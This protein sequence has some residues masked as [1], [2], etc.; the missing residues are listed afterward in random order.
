MAETVAIVGAGLMGRVLALTLLNRGFRVTLF[1]RDE[2]AAL[3]SC[4]YTGAGMLAPVSEMETASPAIAALGI[5]ALPLWE[6]L[7]TELPEPVFFQRAGTLLVAHIPEQAE[8]ARLM[9]LLGKKRSLLS[10]WMND[11]LCHIS[12]DSL[13]GATQDAFSIVALHGERLRQLES[14][15]GER[16]QEGFL[17]TDEGQ[18]D[19]RQLLTAT[20]HALEKQNIQ[21]ISG[22]TVSS[23]QLHAVDGRFFDRVV[24]CRGLGAKPDITQLRGVRGEL[25]RV[26]AP[27][28]RITRPIRLMHPRYPLYIAPREANDFVI[29]ATSLETEN[30]KPM[31]LQSALELLS[32]ACSIHP[33][34]L[35]ASILE[36][37]VN[38]RPTLSSHLPCI[39]VSSGLL[40][41]N[42]LYRHGFLMAPKLAALIADWLDT[43]KPEAP[44]E[45]LFE[46]M[47]EECPLYAHFN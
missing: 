33:G 18:I 32:A 11:D 17:I 39:Q 42:G 45:H 47:T 7:I 16:F 44:Y 41:V 8:L 15:L 4:A 36:M 23:I 20:K 10:G 12:S 31:T 14:E 22:Y 28:V 13:S 35:E 37:G 30:Q 34:F 40:R 26:H 24:D 29:G 21:W 25:I 1:D 46:T 38:C 27:D 3:M 5:E 19:N 2:P 9:R 6:S 43:G